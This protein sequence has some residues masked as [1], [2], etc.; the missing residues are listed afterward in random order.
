[1]DFITVILIAVG[2]AM[3]AFAVSIAKGISV[4]IDRRRSAILLA[5][6]FGGFQGM[7]PVIGWFAGLGLR[8]VI[9]EVDHWVAFGLL[10]FIG[11]KMIH[12]APKSENGKEA[13][14]T[15]CVAIALAVA[16]SIDALMVGL[17]FAFL[18]TPILV[19][20]IVIGVVTLALSYLG[21][22]FGSKMGAMFG[23]KVRVLGGLILI[24][25]GIRILIEH[26]L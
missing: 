23:R 21:F 15:L 6:L 26:M 22:A 12:D 2:L 24:L 14:V 3:D 8:D 16:T 4:E 5:S 17:S 11:A 25:I 9:M 20:V 10:G 19:P 7:M 13:D 1:M 18:E